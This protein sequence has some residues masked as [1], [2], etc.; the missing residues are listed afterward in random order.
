MIG[1]D[2]RLIVIEEDDAF[3]P[4][5]SDTPTWIETMW[6]PFW[7]PDES[8]SASARVWFSPNAGQQGGAIAGWHGQSKGLFGDRWTEPFTDPPDL[9][10]LR[11]KRGLHIECIEPLTRYHI[12]QET[13]NFK[14]DIEFSAI[15]APNPV[16]PEESP[17][18]FAGHF[19]QPGHVTG[20]VTFHGRTLPIDCYSIRD[21]SWGPRL[22][23]DELRLGNAHAT[24]RN[25]SFFTYVNPT[26]DASERITSGYLLQD[27]ISA[28][29][30]SGLRETNWLDDLPVS[31]RLTAK[32]AAGREI[33]VEGECIN[34]M[35][36]NAGNGVYAVLNLVRWENERGVSW[37][38]NHDIWSERAWLAAGRPKL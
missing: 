14:L 30:V 13:E 23:P 10:N 19:E 34:T 16:P 11:L 21:R 17:G 29:I 37:G 36:S 33:Q 6:F 38:E 31:L 35:A 7:I 1:R 20:E 9:K 26:P 27:G 18:M 25:F 5:T 12:C 2:P 22:M 4:P 32:D 28:R 8:L 24:S 3:P 15:M